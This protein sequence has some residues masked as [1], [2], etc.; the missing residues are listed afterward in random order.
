MTA[1]ESVH[2]SGIIISLFITPHSHWGMHGKSHCQGT[3]LM[4]PTC[5]VWLSDHHIPYFTQRQLIYIQSWEK[6][7]TRALSQEQ[8]GGKKERKKI[9]S[10]KP[11]DQRS[12]AGRNF[13]ARNF[14]ESRWV[15][16][17]SVRRDSKWFWKSRTPVSCRSV[18]HHRHRRT[19]RVWACISLTTPGIRRMDRRD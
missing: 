14:G 19:N 18:L 6:F 9:E 12:V 8:P 16:R 15:V 7:S 10:R 5:C 17:A 3:L 13:R 2:R 4:W 11:C 1:S